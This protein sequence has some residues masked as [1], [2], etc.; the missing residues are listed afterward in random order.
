[1]V[2]R[3]W[4]SADDRGGKHGLPF[5]P[6]DNA[7]CRPDFRGDFTKVRLQGSDFINKFNAPQRREI[8]NLCI[9]E[10]S[11]ELCDNCVVV[12]YAV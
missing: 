12:Y 7:R 5:L 9:V 11:H 6:D 10:T 1:M 8:W 3:R 2:A 4:P